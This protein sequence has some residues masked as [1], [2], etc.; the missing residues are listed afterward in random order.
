MKEV[1]FGKVQEIIISHNYFKLNFFPRFQFF[2][3]IVSHY[4]FKDLQKV[5]VQ[6][7]AIFKPYRFVIQKDQVLRGTGNSKKLKCKY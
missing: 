7:Y 3:P 2:F 4:L 5:V 6:Q 1:F